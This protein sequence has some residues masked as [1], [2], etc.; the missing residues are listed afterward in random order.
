MTPRHERLLVVG[1]VL[2]AG[3]L[4]LA[5][6]LRLPTPVLYWDEVHYDSFAARYASAWRSIA[7]PGEFLRQLDTAF[8]HSIQ[9]GEA[10]SACVGLIYALAGHHPTAV[11]AV[12]ALV[13]SAACLLIYALARELG[14]SYVGVIALV[15]AGAYEPFIFSAAR[16]QTETVGSFL[17]L[18]GLWAVVST[19]A[20]RRTWRFVA[21]GGVTAV[22]MLVRPVF[23]FLFPLLLAMIVIAHSDVGW[24]GWLRCGTAFSVGFFAL[25]GPR[26]VLTQQLLGRAVWSGTLDPRISLYAGIVPENVGWGTTG[27]SFAKPPR[28][29]LREVL[30][31]RGAAKPTSADYQR[32]AIRTLFQH[33]TRSLPVLAHKL[34]QAWLRPYNNSRQRLF[35]SLDGQRAWHQAI[36]L[37]A[38]IGMPLALRRRRIGV[39]LIA[40]TMYLLA[41]YL[42]MQIEVRYFAMTL[43]FLMMFAALAASALAGGACARWRTRRLGGVVALTAVVIGLAV[44]AHVLSPARV[45]E[46]MGDALSPRQAHDISVAIGFALLA[47][48][49]LLVFTLLSAQLPV[50]WATAAAIVPLV[51]GAVTF[52]FGRPLAASWRE[53]RAP[54][55]PNRG[56]VRRELTLPADLPSPLR[57]EFRLDLLAAGDATADLVICV[58]GREVRRFIGGPRRDDAVPLP[59]YYEELFAA[60]RRGQRPWHGWYAAPVPLE[61]IHALSTIRVEARLEG[62]NG[63]GSGTAVFGDY[64]A[65]GD[66]ARY[67]GPSVFAPGWWGDVSIYKYLADGDARMRRQ[68]RINASGDSSFD[69]GHEWSRRDLSSEPGRQYGRYRMFLL[70]TYPEGRV[71]VF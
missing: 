66:G 13:S 14:G 46:Q 39:P 50:R 41:A 1:I 31:E 58:N 16:L 6:V 67:D 8:K 21:A 36:L 49:A 70:L 19:A 23:Q 37:L 4:R 35:M 30:S 28:G 53:W 40:T 3:V 27:V 51:I 22:M 68:T 34:Y 17:C 65:G 26:L 45:L 29:A 42:A 9:K 59:A 25:I 52:G 11:F 43:P 38:A 44:A 5:F 71:L 15:L 54:L 56:G 63:T 12:Q 62:A 33:P 69:D 24:R 47:G 60:Q 18:L 57:A 10:Y 2:L 64:P 7:E 61:D 20:P 55:I 32:A 48:G